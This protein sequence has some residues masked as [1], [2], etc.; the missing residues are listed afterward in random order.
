[1]RLIEVF[2]WVKIKIMPFWHILKFGVSLNEITNCSCGV[3]SGKY[4]KILGIHHLHNVVIG[5]Y[6]YIAKNSYISNTIIGRYCSIGPNFLCGWGIHPIHGISTSPMFY[7]TLKQNGYSVCI[8]DKI[9]ERKPIFIGNDVFIGANVTVLD[10]VS[11]GDGAII[12]AGAVVS[13]DIPPYAVAIGS[14]IQIVKYRFDSATIKR[15]LSIEWWKYDEKRIHYLIEQN[16]FDIPN[17][18]VKMNSAEV[19][20]TIITVSYNAV[21]TIEKT[22]L[23]VINQTYPHIEYIIIDGGSVDGTV[24]IIKKYDNKISYWISEHDEGIYDAMNKG[25]NLAHGDWIYFLG[26]D[27]ILFKK[28]T[29]ESVVTNFVD[30]D[31]VYYGNV[32]LKR[33]G[34][35]YL[36]K[37]DK[38]KLSITNLNHQSVFYPR[39]V[40]EKYRYDIKYLIYADYVLNI[41]C[42]GDKNYNT[43]YIDEVI[44][45]YNEIGIS[46]K[47]IDANFEK[48]R[49]SLIYKYLGAKCVLYSF[50]R[51]FL[52]RLK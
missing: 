7:S 45:Y 9:I 18:F 3:K 35:I 11:I 50:V 22:I 10:G 28:H 42:W 43:W 34:K 26:A 51:L 13:K 49:N 15:F 12:G 25:V 32:V 47:T 52:H 23:S 16:F 20:I 6:T 27:D 21:A 37:F 38:Y 2:Q 36:G 41:K 24:D 39:R 17:F 44:A 1:M 30:F 46:S 5:D 29:I 33:S 14:P 40:F 31:T 19:Q 48:D 4:V 8:Y